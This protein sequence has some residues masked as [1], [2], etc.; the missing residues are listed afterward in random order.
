MPTPM[1][2][3]LTSFGPFGTVVSNPTERLV[4]Y[5]ATREVPDHH[6]TTC[7]LPVSFARAP[8]RLRAALEQGGAEGHPF[9]NVLMLGVA[10]GSKVWRVERFGRN[11]DN[12]RLPDSDGFLPPERSIVPDAP[13]VLPVSFP[14]ETLVTALERAGRRPSRRSRRARICA[15]MGCSCCCAICSIPAIRLA[16]V[17]CTFPPMTGRSRPA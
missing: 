3:L 11:R 6:L 14:V 7:V 12:A 1:Q 8:E 16:P 15:I 10:T 5:F 17:S 13:E 9:D 4:A 2:T